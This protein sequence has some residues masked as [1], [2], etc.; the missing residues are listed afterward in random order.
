MTIYMQPWHATSSSAWL[1]TLRHL[2]SGGV[3]HTPTCHQVLRGHPFLPDALRLVSRVRRPALWLPSLT[4]SYEWVNGVNYGGGSRVIVFVVVD[5]RWQVRG[6]RKK[7]SHFHSHIFMGRICQRL[8]SRKNN[9]HDLS[10]F[11]SMLLFLLLRSLP[12]FLSNPFF[13]ILEIHAINTCLSF[14][15]FF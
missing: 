9:L 3:D 10:S 15:L 14:L 1:P 2:S 7:K 4:I 11:L 13:H 12:V 8:W 5:K 6:R